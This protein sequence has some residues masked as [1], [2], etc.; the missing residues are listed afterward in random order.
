MTQI[1]RDITPI[2]LVG[3]PTDY[4]PEYCYRVVQLMAAGKSEN[5]VAWEF[6]VDRTTLYNWARVNQEFDWAFKLAKTARLALLEGTLTERTLAGLPINIPAYN[7][8]LHKQH[9]DQYPEHSDNNLTI[10][11]KQNQLTE[12][13]VNKKITLL[14]S[15]R[16]DSK[17]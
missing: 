7:L 14:L 8:I 15:K 16:E 3:R 6:K 17:V 2:V 11:L 12:E 9:T 4:K 10:N 1:E 13:E 5:Q